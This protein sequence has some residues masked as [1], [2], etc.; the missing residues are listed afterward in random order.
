MEKDGKGLLIKGSSHIAEAI[1]RLQDK[2]LGK[3]GGT[4]RRSID[5]IKPT[6]EIPG[7]IIRKVKHIDSGGEASFKME[8]RFR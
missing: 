4:G 2:I 1:K 6:K 8:A 3:Q 5:S 7:L